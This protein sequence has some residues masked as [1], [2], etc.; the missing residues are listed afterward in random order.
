V[1]AFPPRSSRWKYACLPSL[2]E[3]SQSYKQ[4]S[5]SGVLGLSFR[6][7]VPLF[8]ALF[9]LAESPPWRVRLLRVEEGVAAAQGRPPE[10]NRHPW[11]RVMTKTTSGEHFG[12]R[13]SGCCTIIPSNG[14]LERRLGHTN[15]IFPNFN[16]FFE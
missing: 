12:Y 4:T 16:D 2:T 8:R 9:G 5:V 1:T 7:P 3:T 15:P 10:Q 13:Y 6:G 14:K 11:H